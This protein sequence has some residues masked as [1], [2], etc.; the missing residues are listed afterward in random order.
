MILIATI[1]G[2]S[3]V[4]QKLNDL[5]IEEMK[6]YADIQE[7][8]YTS[9]GAYTHF[10]DLEKQSTRKVEISFN[11]LKKIEH[12]MKSAKQL[13]HIQRKLSGGL[14]FCEIKYKAV[15]NISKLVISVGRESVGIMDLTN[16][17]DFVVRNQEDIK[18]LKEIKNEIQR[19]INRD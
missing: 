5:Q 14:I 2:C 4:K 11:D 10:D 17:R 1:T 18:L 6:V 3:S 19:L 8:G 9:R 7:M 15:E 12:V 16:Q 13:K